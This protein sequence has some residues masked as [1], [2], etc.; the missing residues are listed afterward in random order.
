MNET[1][2]TKE[3]IEE[4]Y[5]YSIHEACTRLNMGIN[6]LKDLCR[7]YNIARW[8]KVRKVRTKSDYFQCFSI[9]KTKV[10]TESKL[11][12]ITK[13]TKTFT[14]I[15]VPQPKEISIFQPT[16]KEETK[17]HSPQSKISIFN[18]CN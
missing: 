18:L 12:T 13:Q 17:N 14:P 4:N 9:H 5:G 3:Q 6:D 1:H 2:P 8:P 10:S 11:K 16:L 7:S 15:V